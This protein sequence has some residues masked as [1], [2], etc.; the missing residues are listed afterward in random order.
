MKVVCGGEVAGGVGL[1]GGVW[2]WARRSGRGREGRVS[3]GACH[4]TPGIRSPAHCCV[5]TSMRS[6]QVSIE[7]KH[8]VEI[9]KH[10]VGVRGRVGV[11]T[12]WG[13]GWGGGEGRGGRAGGW[14]AKRGAWGARRG[15]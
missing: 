2:R 7:K 4:A 8:T 12:E 9:M 15:A 10:L 14:G 13:E 6:M 1:G 3:G 5:E 11:G